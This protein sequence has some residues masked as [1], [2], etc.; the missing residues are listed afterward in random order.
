VDT[1]PRTEVGGRS[2]SRM[3]IGTNWFLGYSHQSAAKDRFIVDCQD[4]DKVA[5]I[6]EVFVAAGVDTI[7]GLLSNPVMSWA[8]KKAQDRIGVKLIIVDT[9]ALVVKPG[10][11]NLDESAEILDKSA[12]S[13]A[14]FCLPHVDTT[15][16]LLDRTTRTLREMDKVCAMIRERGMIPGLSTHSP[17][18]IIYADESGLDV[19]SYIQLYNAIG[20]LMHVEV[21]WVQRIIHE[22]KKPVMTIKPMAAGRLSP[23]PGLAFAWSTLRDCDMV[24]VGALTPDE[25]KEDIEISLS[26]LDQR[27]SNTELQKTRSKKSLEK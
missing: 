5:A 7:M 16:A 8:I 15:D 3:I 4:A 20:F 27:A 2:L 22:A 1:F 19:E 12:A 14:D 13:G 26:I 25:A 6:I 21:D 11:V 24:T 17:E 23:L 9:P 18:S 10:G